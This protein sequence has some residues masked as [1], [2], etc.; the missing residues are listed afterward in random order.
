MVTKLFVKLY[1]RDSTSTKVNF[2][3]WRM[4]MSEDERSEA[5]NNSDI[6]VFYP[7]DIF[8]LQ[9]ST[10]RVAIGKMNQ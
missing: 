5:F 4:P 2:G 1:E 6:K 9:M 3:K 10:A 8:I 7:Q